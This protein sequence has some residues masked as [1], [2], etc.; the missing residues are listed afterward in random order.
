MAL[1]V[2]NYNMAG[3]LVSSG[4]EDPTMDDDGAPPALPGN[5]RVHQYED[6]I[7][8]KP[9]T[10]AEIESIT[11]RPVMRP[12]KQAKK[13]PAVPNGIVRRA[14][15]APDVSDRRRCLELAVAAGETD[16]DKV[17]AIAG[18]YLGFLLEEELI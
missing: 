8:P 17:L 11:G 15:P 3:A 18:R 13:V 5:V 14:A 4:E 16:P 6:V 12:A 7:Q 9:P 10:D 2:H 1:R